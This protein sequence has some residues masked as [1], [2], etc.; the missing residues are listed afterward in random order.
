[1]RFFARDNI[2]TARGRDVQG[3]VIASD[4]R[5]DFPVRIMSEQAAAERHP[6]SIRLTPENL[7]TAITAAGRAVEPHE[8][9][10]SDEKEVHADSFGEPARPQA[11]CLHARHR[12][13]A[14]LLERVERET[15]RQEG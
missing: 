8:Q 12:E 1:M 10:V 9:P 13:K 4:R 7:Q 14:A 3:T 15:G 5:A 6:P 2:E 11:P